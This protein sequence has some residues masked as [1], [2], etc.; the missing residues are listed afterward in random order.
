M[1]LDVDHVTKVYRGGLKANDEITLSID[2]GEAF[3]LLGPNGAGKTT[4]IAQ[5][6]GLAAPTS[7]TITIGGADVVANPHIAREACSYQP[8]SSV[9]ID[10]LTPLQAIELAGRIRGGDKAHMRA[11]AHELVDALD[12]TEWQ[13]KAATLSSGVSRLVAFC[14]AAVR[15]GRIVILD[16]PTNDVDP[17]RRKLLWQ[18]VRALADGGSDRN[19]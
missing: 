18:Q 7:G 12:L 8:Q 9:P 2:T 17:L 5:I 3:G 19:S 6:I 11:R 13:S 10:G 14:M 16:E 1:L 4:L 15:P